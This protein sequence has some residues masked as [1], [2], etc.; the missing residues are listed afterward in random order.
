[1]AADRPKWE[2]QKQNLGE[3]EQGCRQLKLASMERDHNE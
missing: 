1:M 3:E 2:E